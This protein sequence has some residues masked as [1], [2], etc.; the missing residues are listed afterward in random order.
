[1]AAAVLAF[2]ASSPALADTAS[3]TLQIEAGLVA[4]LT[5]SCPKPLTFGVWFVQS[6][7]REG[8]LTRFRL[9]PNV[10]GALPSP[11]L[12]EGRGT[13]V[14]PGP[15]QG[16]CLVTGSV[17]ED[18]TEL[19]V[20]FGTSFVDL[21]AEAVLGLDAPGSAAGVRVENFLF[22]PATQGA[23]VPSVSAPPKIVDGQAEFAVGGE[24]VI[25]N[26]LTAENF[27]GYSGS[28]TITVTEQGL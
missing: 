25:P 28:I 1:M 3:G 22:R 16:E 9:T 26:N 27:G 18:N 4:G 20:S 12:V 19:A 23:G 13:S 8:G 24:L 2:G 10:P 14:L 11:N 7:D 5:L 21:A 6:A 17:A 15:G